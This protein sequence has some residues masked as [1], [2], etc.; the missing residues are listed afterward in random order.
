MTLGFVM[1]V[2]IIT[3]MNMNKVIK[4]RIL[5]LI[6]QIGKPNL[7][8]VETELA[9]I[10]VLGTTSTGRIN[11]E[12]IARGLANIIICSRLSASW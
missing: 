2:Y 5:V 9:S 12:T 3:I 7:D 6:V 8:W 10:F 4:N 1:F 11:L